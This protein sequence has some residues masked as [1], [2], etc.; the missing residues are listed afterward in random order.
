MID[1]SDWELLTSDQM[2]WESSSSGLRTYLACYPFQGSVQYQ[3]MDLSDPVFVPRWSV[4]SSNRRPGNT[5]P[6][7]EPPQ[8]QTHRW[9]SYPMH[10]RQINC[11]N[12]INSQQHS[13]KPGNL[14]RAK[15]NIFHVASRNIVAWLPTG[16]D[17]NQGRHRVLPQFKCRSFIDNDGDL[18]NMP[19]ETSMSDRADIC[20]HKV[21]VSE[22]PSKR[23]ES[24]GDLIVNLQ[25]STPRRFKSS[26]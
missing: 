14:E 20:V 1:Q 22:S 26:N 3:T 18:G 23:V 13:F 12:L 24:T 21:A 2:P 8:Y 11:I 16:L 5:L 9:G 25:G 6:S 15:P 17:W 7:I 10:G 19:T 4:S